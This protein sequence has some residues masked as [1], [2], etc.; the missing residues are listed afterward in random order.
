MAKVRSTKTKLGDRWRTNL[1]NEISKFTR[2]K[3][4][5][6]GGKGERIRQQKEKVENNKLSAKGTKP[7]MNKDFRA[8]SLD[9]FKEP[10]GGKKKNNY[11][12]DN[13]LKKRK[14]GPSKEKRVP[15]QYT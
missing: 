1:R 15:G 6:C 3:R 10:W 2:E 9:F 7:G 13:D 12:N 8:T 14:K 11:K 4:S 5:D